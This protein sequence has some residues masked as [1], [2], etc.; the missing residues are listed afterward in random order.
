MTDTKHTFAT[1]EEAKEWLVLKQHA[2]ATEIDIKRERGTT[3]PEGDDPILERVT[4]SAGFVSK[5]LSCLVVVMDELQKE[6]S[7]CD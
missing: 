2:I 4:M 3:T 1:F 6:H 5:L 7:T